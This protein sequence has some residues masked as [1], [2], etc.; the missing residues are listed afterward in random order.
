VSDCLDE[1]FGLFSATQKSQFLVFVDVLVGVGLTS[2]TPWNEANGKIVD[3]KRLI[4]RESR[5]K[6]PDRL[7]LR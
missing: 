2:F 3:G 5:K 1:W 4:S 7:E 6:R